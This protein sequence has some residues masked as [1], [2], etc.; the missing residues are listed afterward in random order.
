MLLC[1]FLGLTNQVCNYF[2]FLCK[3]YFEFENLKGECLKILILGKLGFKLVFWKSISSHTHAFYSLYSMLWGV[4]SKNQVIF[5]KNFVLPKFQLIQSIFRSIKIAFKILS[6]PLSVSI[7]RNLFS[8]NRKL[9]IRFLKIWFWLVQLIFFKTFQAFLSLSDSAKAFH[10]IFVIF[11]W[12]FC[13][14]FLS[15]GR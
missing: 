1:V 7:N 11:L 10:Q 15:Q 4:F 13:K 3:T 8:I 14:V 9:W 6:E 12:S 5:V 2:E